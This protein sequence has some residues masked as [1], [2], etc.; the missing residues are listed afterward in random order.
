MAG[1]EKNSTILLGWARDLVFVT[2][3]LTRLPVARMVP[4]DPDQAPRNLAQAAWAFPAV[5]LIVGAISGLTLMVASTLGLHPL[6]L[7]LIAL[8]TGVVVT[9]ALHEDG[10]ADVADGFGGGLDIQSKLTIM[11]DSAIGTYGM[12]ALVF[13][14]II[15]ASALAGMPGPGTATLALISAACISRALMVGLMANLPAARDD[16]LGASAGKPEMETFLTAFAL[17]AVTA[18]VLSGAVAWIL[19]IAGCL[20]AAAMMVLAKRQIGGHTGDVLGATQQVSETAILLAA[21]A[22]LG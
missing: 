20:A 1:S 6:A 21:A 17:A 18:F 22:A 11:R 8:A 12:L 9:G 7:A 3:F 15:R 14:V 13:S 16:G 2:G 10:L 19:L 4:A 5:G